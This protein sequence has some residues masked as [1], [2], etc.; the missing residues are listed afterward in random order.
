[1]S[2]C[3][4]EVA[5]DRVACIE[6]SKKEKKQLVA[7]GLLTARLRPEKRGWCGYLDLLCFFGSC[8]S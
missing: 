2:I 1:M 7:L 3:N 5:S 8:T 4:R 6:A